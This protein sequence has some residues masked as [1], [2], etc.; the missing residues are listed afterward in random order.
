M[1]TCIT[2]LGCKC[3][4]AVQSAG[5]LSRAPSYNCDNLWQTPAPP[6]GRGQMQEY[7]V[8][9]AASK[10]SR[11]VRAKTDTSVACRGSSTGTMPVA[12]AMRMTRRLLDASVCDVN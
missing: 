12:G 8:F 3:D 7:C 2:Y 5:G 1:C 10:P 4:A 11:M 9:L 6:P